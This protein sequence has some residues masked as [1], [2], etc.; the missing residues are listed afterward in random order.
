VQI[1]PFLHGIGICEHLKMIDVPDLHVCV[2]LDPDCFHE[3]NSL[4]GYHGANATSPKSYRSAL[5][6]SRNGLICRWRREPRGRL[7]DPR[8]QSNHPAGDVF[9]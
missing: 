1:E 8:A 7:Q 5:P 6:A 3:N 4:T 9:G 2:D